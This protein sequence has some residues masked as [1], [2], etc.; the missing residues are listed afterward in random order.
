MKTIALL[1]AVILTLGLGSAAHA[2]YTGPGAG[3]PAPSN[4]ADILKDGQDD[5]NVTL[6]GHLVEKVGK[7]KYIFADES[8]KIR[9]DIDHDDFP[10]AAVDEKTMIEITGE[11]EKDFMESPEI[12]V[13]T[14]TIV[15]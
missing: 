3:A 9:V 5:Q 4:V 11:I 1:S 8:G 13:D 10:N 7:E 6:R 15:K 12:D 2:E 14:L